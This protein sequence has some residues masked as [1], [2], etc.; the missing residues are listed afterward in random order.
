MEQMGLID[1]QEE[2]ADLV[3]R[4]GHFPVIGVDTES[5]SFFA[6]RERV[7]L[8]Q[9]ST[10]D[11]DFIVDPLAALDLSSLAN[12]F[13]RPDIIKVFHDGE[14]DI[15]NLKRD[16][17]LSVKGLFDTKVVRSA[18]GSNSLGLASLVHDQ[19][20]V[21]LDKKFQRS[22]WGQ[23]PLSPE[24]INYA[25]LD[26]HYLVP[27][28]GKLQ[29]ELAAALPIIQK[30]VTGEF[31]RLESLKAQVRKVDEWDFLRLKGARRLDP[32]GLSALRELYFS[33]EEKALEK[34]V[35]LVK[36]LSDSILVLL[37]QKRPNIGDDS[38]FAH[39]PGVSR[40]S[41]RRHL[42][43]I[44]TALES[45]TRKGPI[46]MGLLPKNKNTTPDAVLSANE[47]LRTW[48]RTVAENL[49]LD[50]SLVLNRG[51]LE[52]IAAGLPNT[53]DELEAIPGMEDWRVEEF[54]EAILEAVKKPSPK[55][56]KTKRGK[57]N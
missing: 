15:M 45:A 29:D 2:L 40:R 52:A 49:G 20:G 48:R 25:C 46:P 16:L 18:L 26:T 35:P 14:Q 56:R 22:D 33:R 3:S 43:W 31:L 27:L 36:I 24:Q 38:D 41:L 17:G 54:G 51:V 30:F 39:L 50:P 11:A 12:I 28:Y 9:I 37:A 55:T 4:L 8:L 10:V 5:N 23:R 6:Y 34:D 44:K 57:R 1:S 19:F 47:K 32:Q 13:A 53:I 21:V 42:G 7:C